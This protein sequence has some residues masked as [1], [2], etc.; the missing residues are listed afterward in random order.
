MVHSVV[1]TFVPC[2]A[3]VIDEKLREAATNLHL[4]IP[5]NNGANLSRFVSMGCH[6]TRFRNRP[7]ADRTYEE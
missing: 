2:F 4:V 3:A 7:V 5:A 1:G 6:S